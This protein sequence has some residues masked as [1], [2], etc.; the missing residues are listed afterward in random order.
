MFIAF[1]YESAHQTW[2]SQ[3]EDYTV[4]SFDIDE[5]THR[6]TVTSRQ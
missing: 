5:N 6:H 4:A 3:V 1:L 2:Q